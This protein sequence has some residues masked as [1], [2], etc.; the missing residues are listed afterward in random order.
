MVVGVTP[1]KSR[2]NSRPRKPFGTLSGTRGL[3]LGPRL[4]RLIC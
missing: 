4:S 3:G 2:P 1:T